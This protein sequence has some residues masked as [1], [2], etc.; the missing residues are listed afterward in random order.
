M[1]DFFKKSEK[2]PEI[3]LDQIQPQGELGDY[4]AKHLLEILEK[5]K[6]EI[7]DIHDRDATRVSGLDSER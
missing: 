4:P 7:Q 3:D 5:H 2:E 6:K 1:F